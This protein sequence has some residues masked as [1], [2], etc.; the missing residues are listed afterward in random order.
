MQTKASLED[1]KARH[2]STI[3]RR[4]AAKEQLEV[5]NSALEGGM[6][7]SL[8][9]LNEERSKISSELAALPQQVGKHED[10]VDRLVVKSPIRGI[11]HELA[12]KTPGEVVKP[13]DLVARV[14]PLDASVVAEVRVDPK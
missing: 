13:G 1:V 6:A 7:E 14:V 8:K 2:F 5:A 9:L 11:V 12:Q 4:D 10:R 3:G